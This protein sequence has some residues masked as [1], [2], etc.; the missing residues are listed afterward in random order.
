MSNERVTLRDVYDAIGDL[1]AKIDKRYEARFLH[2]ETTV[3]E[4][5]TFRNQLIG[6]ITVLFAVVGLGINFLWD[7]F[8]NQR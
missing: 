4:N 6:K 7:W 3:E 1:E 5:T 2:I 8:F